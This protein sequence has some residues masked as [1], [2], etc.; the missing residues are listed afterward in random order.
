MRNESAWGV[1]SSVFK[2]WPIAQ[3]S[4]ETLRTIN[5][6]FSIWSAPWR[7]EFRWNEHASDLVIST[8][9]FRPCFSRWRLSVWYRGVPV[10]PYDLRSVVWWYFEVRWKVP[11]PKWILFMVAAAIFFFCGKIIQKLLAM[12][13][14]RSKCI[15][16]FMQLPVLLTLSID[17]PK[18]RSVRKSRKD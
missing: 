8:R 3:I 15:N 14:N 1:V 7:C 6:Q 12:D 17:A 11:V 16:L 4:S 10:S 9:Y 13:R 18:K 5:H 2:L